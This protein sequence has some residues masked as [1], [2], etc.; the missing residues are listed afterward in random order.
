MEEEISKN[1]NDGTPYLF[2]GD[3]YT[4]YQDGSGAYTSYMAAHEEE[5]VLKTG[6]ILLLSGDSLASDIVRFTTQSDWSHVGMVIKHPYCQHMHYI[7]ESRLSLGVTLEPL[8][9]RLKEYPVV[10]VRSLRTPLSQEQQR[11]LYL[12]VHDL[13]QYPFQNDYRN[14][15]DSFLGHWSFRMPLLHGAFEPHTMCKHG[16]GI[17]CSELLMEALKCMNCCPEMMENMWYVTRPTS[18]Y[19]PHDFSDTTSTPSFITRLYNKE[20]IVNKMS[21]VF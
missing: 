18:T 13:L 10:A 11:H 7:L 4:P 21:F 3:E 8:E 15:V 16:T 1:M 12:F 14:L 6:D 19:V 20:H 9:E 17:L 2:W 5:S